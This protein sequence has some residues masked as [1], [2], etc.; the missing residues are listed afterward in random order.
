MKNFLHIN[1]DHHLGNPR[2]WTPERNHQAWEACYLMLEEFLSKHGRN[3]TLYIVCGIQGGGKSTWIT[4]NAEE[5]A[6]CS[7]VLDA[8][9][10]GARHRARALSLAQTHGA[11]AEAIW[12]NT[13]LEKALVWNRMRPVDQQ[14]PDE[15][16]RAVNENF[17][18]PSLAEGFSAVHVVNDV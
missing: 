8:A 17:E 14:V 15:A 12:I 7:T 18:P 1:P 16:I 9:L 13:N 10:P 6:P 2:I 4:K 11:R 3:A 5:L